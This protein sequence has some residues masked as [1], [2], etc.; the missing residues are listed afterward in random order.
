MNEKLINIVIKTISK[1]YSIHCEMCFKGEDS[2]IEDLYFS[3]SDIRRGGLDV[4]NFIEDTIGLTEEDCKI[5]VERWIK[6]KIDIDKNGYDIN[7]I[8]FQTKSVSSSGI[9]FS[10]VTYFTRATIVY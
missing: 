7:K 1:M 9:S 6:S 8:W 2:Y 10:G 4:S 3:E 5:I